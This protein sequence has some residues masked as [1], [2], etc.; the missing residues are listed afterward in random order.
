MA[1]TFLHFFN[2][3]I[4]YRIVKTTRAARRFNAETYFPQ[5]ESP[6]TRWLSWRQSALAKLPSAATSKIL[7]SMNPPP[8]PLRGM[9]PL[10][11]RTST[12]RLQ[13]TD[14]AIREKAPV[15][16]WTSFRALLQVLIFG[17]VG[18]ICMNSLPAV[19]FMA[20]TFKRYLTPTQCVNPDVS[21][22]PLWR[23]PP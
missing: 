7:P 16:P 23:M 15:S 5:A 13:A 2:L 12:P 6:V 17:V 21:Q 11:N 4:C 9:L 14:E 20:H 22:L 19:A 1:I 8:T 18:L 10:G 3:N